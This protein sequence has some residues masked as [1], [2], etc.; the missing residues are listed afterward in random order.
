MLTSKLKMSSTVTYKPI[1]P[2]GEKNAQKTDSDR[3]NVV[4]I[5]IWH[6]IL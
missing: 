2:H 1:Q 6:H 3:Y 4:I 5:Y